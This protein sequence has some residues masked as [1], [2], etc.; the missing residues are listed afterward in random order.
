MAETKLPKPPV[1][2][3]VDLR[4][5]K[6]MPLFGM[7]IDV[8]A[9]GDINQETSPESMVIAI[10]I[11]LEFWLP[12]QEPV[13]P[14][15]ERIVERLNRSLPR[16]NLSVAVFEEHRPDI[17]KF[18]TVLE[19]GRWVPNPGIFSLVGDDEHS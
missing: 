17:E 6:Y 19:D 13:L 15:V 14:D 2:A 18:F 1:P 10:D 11:I 8:E 7:F 4:D 9:M 12:A 3:N 16:H 5:L